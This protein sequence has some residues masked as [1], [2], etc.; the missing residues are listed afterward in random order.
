MSIP[1]QEQQ[2]NTA[3]PLLN[4]LLRGEI[5]ATETYKKAVEK[6]YNELAAQQLAQIARHHDEAV[7]KLTAHVRRLGGEPSTDSGGWGIWA[8]AVQGMARLLG[9]NSSIQALQAGETHGL[10]EYHSALNSGKLP[11]DVE[12]EIQNNLI[13]KQQNHIEIL[14]RMGTSAGA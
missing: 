13:P 5:S 6:N 11:R 2:K 1:E 9:P 4:S 3:I 12:S 14:G 10:N 7:D 8:K